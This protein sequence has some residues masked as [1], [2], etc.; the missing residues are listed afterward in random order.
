MRTTSPL[1]TTS[2][3][4]T[5]AL[6][7]LA[8]AVLG[9]GPA[10]AAPQRS[11]QIRFAPGSSSGAVSGA[12]P[13]GGA[14][15]YAFRARAGQTAVVHLQRSDDTLR[16][17]LVAPDGS[18]LHTQMGE[19]VDARVALR[20]GGSYRLT[21]M[22]TDPGAYR[23]T[24]TIPATARSS[25]LRFARGASAGTVSARLAAG[26]SRTWR[27][28]ARGGQRAT[29]HLTDST[30]R[31]RWS[32]RSPDGTALRPA[33]ARRTGTSALPVTGEYALTVSSDVGTTCTLRLSIPA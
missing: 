23:L 7:L 18:P 13:A 24:L 31:A 8:T 17:T 10:S 5:A 25:E 9:T 11:E 15:A 3:T 33:S 1:S 4:T 29:V 19:A 14:K 2:T 21:V 26:A 30:G 16:W 12:L 32:L 28:R 20:Q 27:L 6:A 22:T